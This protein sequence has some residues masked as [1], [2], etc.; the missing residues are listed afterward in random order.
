MK[1]FTQ[2]TQITLKTEDVR[3]K[4]PYKFPP[5]FSMRLHKSDSGFSKQFDF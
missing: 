2:S 4:L 5:I 3:H 1:S